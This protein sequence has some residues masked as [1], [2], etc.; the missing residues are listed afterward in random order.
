PCVG[1]AL[2]QDGLWLAAASSEG[3]IH[4]SA[5]ASGVRRANLTSPRKIY[6]LTFDADADTLFTA[7]DEGAWRWNLPTGRGRLWGFHTSHVTWLGVAPKGEFLAAGSTKA[8]VLFRSLRL[9]RVRQVIG[10]HK[11]P[12]RSGAFSP[13]GSKLATAAGPSDGVVRLWD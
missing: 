2:S 5:T 12:V 6:S 8:D 9:P 13:D 11:T 10:V 1:L 3:G 7:T 4:V